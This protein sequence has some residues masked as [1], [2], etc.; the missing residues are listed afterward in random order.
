[1]AIASDC[2]PFD[3]YFPVTVVDL[4]IDHPSSMLASRYNDLSLEQSSCV[5][6]RVVDRACRSRLGQTLEQENTGSALSILKGW[7]LEHTWLSQ[8]SKDG[9]LHHHPFAIQRIVRHAEPQDNSNGNNLV[10]YLA[11]SLKVG[12]SCFMIIP[13]SFPSSGLAALCFRRL[14]IYFFGENHQSISLRNLIKY[15]IEQ[16]QIPW[17]SRL[18]VMFAAIPTSIAT[19]NIL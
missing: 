14:C 15:S 19:H 11:R 5:C 3:K 17:T 13:I 18:R 7:T 16:H 12:H 6:T 4:P 1:M 10:S 8:S 2:F 9:P